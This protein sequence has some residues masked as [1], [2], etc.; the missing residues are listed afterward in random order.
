MRNWHINWTKKECRVSRFIKRN[1]WQSTKRLN[2]GPPDSNEISLPLL[3]QAKLLNHEHSFQNFYKKKIDYLLE[4]IN[5]ALSETIMEMKR[6]FAT[7]K[8]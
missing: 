6:R 5:T 8:Y 4:K 3:S 1:K 2:I 7:I